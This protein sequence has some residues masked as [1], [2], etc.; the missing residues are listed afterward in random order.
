MNDALRI[1]L[2][3]LSEL[4]ESNVKLQGKVETAD[5]L[6]RSLQIKLNKET[7]ARTELEKSNIGLQQ[8]CEALQSDLN[9]GLNWRNR[10]K[11]G[12]N[13]LG[14]LQSNLES[15]DEW[16]R[17][18]LKLQQK[19]EAY[20]KFNVT[21]QRDITKVNQSRA[22]LRQN[23]AKLEGKYETAEVLINTL[24]FK[25][26]KHTEWELSKAE[27]L[28]KVEATEEFIEYSKEVV[29]TLHRD[30]NK[31]TETCNNLQKSNAEL[32]G[33]IEANEESTKAIV[34][35]LR[36]KLKEV[37]TSR[38]ICQLEIATLKAQR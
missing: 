31:V 34:E 27:F 22:D 38:D 4:E 29:G 6:I 25:L 15:R 24:Q 5:R 28:G 9:K 13:R 26:K 21:L 7:W 33:I 23:N 30:L 18:H 32:H 12:N 35:G 14:T 36:H 1:N 16:E 11:R 2:A 19:C 20:E 37:I 17:N 10:L 3:K 8:K